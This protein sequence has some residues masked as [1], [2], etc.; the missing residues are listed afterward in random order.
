[1]SRFRN[2]MRIARAIL[3]REMGDGAI[4]FAWPNANPVPLRIQVRVHE[5]YRALGDMAGTNFHYAEMQTN[6]P[7]AVFWLNSP[8]GFV[9]SRGMVFITEY[10]R[11]YRIETVMPPDDQTQNA[12]VV[13]LLPSD[14]IGM[15]QYTV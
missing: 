4:I 13:E 5:N 8:D 11:G 3:H 10:G 12:E 14:M 6:S 9:P 7:I 1:M 2:E 15:P